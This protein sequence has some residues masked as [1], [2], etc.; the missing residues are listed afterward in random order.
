M[1][2]EDVAARVLGHPEVDQNAE[3]ERIQPVRRH[4]V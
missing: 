3:Y 2:L 1:L 4:V